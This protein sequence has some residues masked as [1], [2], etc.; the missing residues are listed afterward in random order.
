MTSPRPD[1]THRKSKRYVYDQDGTIRLIDSSEAQLTYL[2]ENL[3]VEQSETNVRYQC[4]V[5]GQF[6][7]TFTRLLQ[8]RVG[9]ECN[10]AL[11]RAKMILADEFWHPGI[12]GVREAHKALMIKKIAR[13]INKSGTL[14]WFRRLLP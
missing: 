2:D 10:C 7:R 4:E 13:G 8:E 11:T 5:C 12:H 6:V 14:S 9:F 1:L 3:I